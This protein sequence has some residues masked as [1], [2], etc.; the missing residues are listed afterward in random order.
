MPQAPYDL[1]TFDCYGTLIDWRS[2]I[3]D[4]FDRAAAE[5]GKSVE[6][7][8]I[9]ALH[10]EI[11]PLVQA[12][13]FR[14]YR[15]VLEETARQIG[16]RLGWQA[17]PAGGWSFLPESLARW[18]P[19]PDTV[20]GLHRLRE[21]GLA[22]GILSNVDD[23]LIAASL[24]LV[25]VEFEFVIT[26][27]QVRSYKPARP[28]FDAGRE[29]AADRR[30]LHVAQSVFHDIA[31]ASDLG[32]PGVWINRLGEPDDPRPTATHPDVA[33]LAASLGDAR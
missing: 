25:E 13:E 22:L 12:Q 14:P 21:A 18:Q 26:A 9:L 1:L 3:A 7:D 5:L 17:A 11:E 19:F 8:R 31:P 4:A 15:D 10:A 30:W 6:R 32:I 16:Q 23:D 28:H 33:A 29:R 20:S 2:G 27:Q 24:E